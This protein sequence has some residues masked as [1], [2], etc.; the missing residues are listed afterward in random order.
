M[1]R[2]KEA[3]FQMY[4]DAVVEA[5][6]NKAYDI[7][8]DDE[9]NTVFINSYYGDEVDFVW[10]DLEQMYDS[11]KV[12]PFQE[13]IFYGEVITETR[14]YHMDSFLLSFRFSAL[15]EENF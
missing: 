7:Q 2:I 13:D 10:E 1:S 4:A 9:S 6:L 11:N 5:V 14:R 12:K 8:I 15:C 3:V